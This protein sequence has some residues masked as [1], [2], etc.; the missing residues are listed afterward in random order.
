MGLN[1][2]QRANKLHSE[3]KPGANLVPGANPV[4]GHWQIRIEPTTRSRVSNLHRNR[5][6]GVTTKIMS[7]NQRPLR[8]RSGTFKE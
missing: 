1:L 5:Y 7:Q 8:I 2:G 6:R 4:L 3:Q